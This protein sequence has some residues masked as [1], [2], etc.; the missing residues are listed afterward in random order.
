MV[1]HPACTAQG[2]C[3]ERLGTERHDT[4]TLPLRRHP[5]WLM[6]QGAHCAHEHLVRRQRRRR[7]RAAPVRRSRRQA[8]HRAGRQRCRWLRHPQLRRRWRWPA[9]RPWPSTPTAQAIAACAPLQSRPRSRCSAIRA[10]WPTS[11]LRPA[12]RSTW[13]VAS[14]SLGGVDDLPRLL[15]QVHRVLKPGAPFVVAMRHP[16]AAMFGGQDHTATAAY[17]A[18]STHLHRAVHGVRAQQL[19]ARRGA[20]VER[21]AGARPAVPRGVRAPRPQARRLSAQLARPHA[22][23]YSASISSAGRGRP[24][25]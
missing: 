10:T 2:A 21:S 24:K 1:D 22:S 19:P 9:P 13:C 17:G 23:E 4:T 18:S 5:P 14:H 25:R 20:R 12:P 7:I 6:R 11:A 8:G 16:V 3:A 15:R